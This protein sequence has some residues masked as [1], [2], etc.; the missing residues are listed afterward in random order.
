MTPDSPTLSTAPAIE[1]IF[2]ATLAA[3]PGVQLLARHAA[4][5]ADGHTE[6]TDAIR[7]LVDA[8][9]GQITWKEADILIDFVL[10]VPTL[11]DDDGWHRRPTLLTMKR[12]AQ[13]VLPLP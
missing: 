12:I 5:V 10:V 9:G 3:T 2:G 8:C 11:A 13:V 7:A 1:R 6:H 4:A